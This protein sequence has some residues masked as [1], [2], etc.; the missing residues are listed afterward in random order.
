MPAPVVTNFGRNV[1]FRPAARYAPRSEAEVLDILRAHRGSPVR[2][3]GRLHSWSDVTVC[4]SVLLDLRRLDAVAVHADGP[5]PWVE[6]GAGCQIKRVVVEL[7]KTG[8]T[9]PSL[10]LI[11]EQT[12]AGATA[13]GTHG[14]GRHSLSHYVR[15]VR[16]ASYDP[17]T[18]EPTIREVTGGA[19]LRAA[20]C[21]LG[22]LGIVTKMLLP[23]RRQYQ[24]EEHFRRYDRLDDVLDQEAGYDLQQFFLVPW[25]WDYLAQHR[26]EVDR[27]RSVLAPLYRLYW[28]AGMD[29]GLHVLVRLLARWF[30]SFCTRLAYRHVIPWLVPR[31]WKVVDRSDRQLT[32][33]HELFRHIEIEIFVR[34]SRLA[35]AMGYV[36]WLLRQAGGETAEPPADVGER[37]RSSGHWWAVD[38]VRGRYL[39]HYPV[40]VRKVLPDETLISMSSGDEPW[41]ALSFISYARPSRR[42]GFFRFATVLA[43]TM[44]VLFDSRPHWGKVCLLP[45][46]ELARLYPGLAEFAAIQ[47][48]LDPGG[49][50]GNA[51][52]REVLAAAGG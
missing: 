33:Q 36:V 26:C 51:W 44:A 27:P 37:L 15:G 20:R 4:E 16:L 23:I 13:T 14:S 22:C 46:A 41:Y 39:H 17:H 47:K 24:V 29:V 10:G 8:H 18:G 3:V 42:D 9:L 38:E 50:F 45:A 2:A 49:V 31:G 25:R 7:Q 28:A 34:G 12:V 11:D 5:D 19:E 40:C 43:G 35:A 48:R 52:L 21:S 1:T 32:M 30:P 6:V